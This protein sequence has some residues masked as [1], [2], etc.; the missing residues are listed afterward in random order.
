M[1]L[2]DEQQLILNH[3]RN[4]KNT[5][6]QAVA[7]S[8]K[9]STVLSIAAE[10][11]EKSILQLTYNSSLRAE[12][13]EKVLNLN[14][15]N[16]KI[17]TYHSL[18]VRYYLPTCYTDTG[19]RYLLHNKLAP[20]HEIPKYDII[21]ID[22]TQDMTLLY[23]LLV[24]KFISDICSQTGHK[25]QLLI[26]GDDLQSLYEFKGSDSRFLT[27]AHEI[28]KINPYLRTHEFV[29]CT[30]KMSYRITNQMCSF[31]NE[32][33]LGNPRMNA[34]R[35]GVPV[36]YIRN[37]RVNIEKI[38]IYEIG[39][40]LEQGVKPN[41]IFILGASVKGSNSNVRRMENALVSKNIPCH[42]P[43]LE[44]KI[45]E[46]VI[47]G[48]VVFSTFHTVKGRQRPHV[49]IVG[50][51]N[52]YFDYYARNLPKSKCPNTLY[53]GATRATQCLYLLESDDCHTDRP[54]EF[55]KKTHHEMK[56]LDY[57]KFNGIPRTLFFMKDDCVAE[58]INLIDKHFITPTELIKFIP[59]SVIEEISPIIDRIFVKENNDFGELEIPTVIKTKDNY[60]EEVS[61]LNGIAI[62]IMYYDCIY[63]IFN[64]G[65]QKPNIL[66]EMIEQ[67]IEL[68]KKNEHIYLKE[69]FVDLPKENDKISDYLYL[70][71]F[72][73]ATYE[74]LYFKLKQ[75]DDYNWLRDD[76]F[77]QC[78]ERLNHV[79]KNEC[80][81]VLPEME[82]TIISKDQ[83]EKH[84]KIDHY[85]SQFF[86]PNKRF[87]FTGRVDLVTQKSIWELKCTSKLALDHLI[88]V[89]IYAWLWKMTTDE[90]KEFKIFNIKTGEMNVL[91]ASMDDL[92]YI[93]VTLLQGKYLEHEPKTD[94][95]FLLETII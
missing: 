60:Y 79:L 25:I 19:I 72:Y 56:T 70:A 39:K 63:E 89:V 47:D 77:Q 73:V 46:R 18:A 17:H 76:I 80:D 11:H 20:V 58:S 85:L 34:C 53:V 54:M 67:N 50:F 81:N 49:F 12:I 13:N 94:E 95:E 4:G 35:N 87:R 2:S 6:V 5:I 74:K 42:V 31:V 82:K 69:L 90:E 78:K 51:D 15:K 40:L 57:V 48:K 84:V 22:E 64:P 62:P 83:E 3:V 37:A 88:Q 14:L 45:D 61:D 30:M 59:E 27:F 1:K 16:I 66:Y 9:S 26:L 86:P 68:M 29:Q 55:L 52:S 44:D 23:F 33:M 91:N 93:V 36:K 24:N 8:G 65:S 92:N 10:L 21:V 71:N 38:V 75:I 7:G 32:V 43:I 41:E 28:W